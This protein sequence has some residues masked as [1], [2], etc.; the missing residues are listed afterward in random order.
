VLVGLGARVVERR[1]GAG[2]DPP[3]QPQFHEQVERG[4]HGGRRRAG[5]RRSQGVAD[6]VGGDVVG[7]PSQLAENHE[8]LRRG[9][10]AAGVQQPD[11]V[12][13]VVRAGVGAGG[14]GHDVF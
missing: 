10:L 14:V 1:A 3:C 6:L 11:E 13:R 2:V 5:Q 12:G 8:A 9:P 4:V 7:T